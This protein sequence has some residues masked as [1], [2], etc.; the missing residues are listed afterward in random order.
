MSS[1][2]PNTDAVTP[3][4][5]RAKKDFRY[6]FNILMTA[7][8][9]SFVLGALVP[10]FVVIFF[11]LVQGGTNLKPSLFT[12]LPPA[13]M[14][15]DTEVKEI[16][17]GFGNALLGT[18]T[19]VGLGSLISVPIGIFAAIF[20]AEFSSPKI[21]RWL[22]F[23]TNILSGVPSIIIGIFAYA[24]LVSRA[25]GLNPIAIG[26][27]NAI[28]GGFAL[29]LIMLPVIVRTT[30]EALQIV[31]KDVRWASV[32]V[33]A[34]NYQT[35]LRVVLPAALPAVATGIT[36]AVARASG[37]TAPL[38]FTAATQDYWPQ[39]LEELLQSP[40]TFNAKISAIHDLFQSLFQPTHSLAVLVYNFATKGDE[41]QKLIAW[42]ASFLLVIMVLL[43]SIISK[44]ATRRKVY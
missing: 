27:F 23:F 30:D 29:S 14:G 7:T 4:S 19:M 25:G 39:G 40:L 32:G 36:L 6:F 11:V 12:Q 3:L 2:L 26:A 1:D 20:L 31:P 35:V 15:L 17:G 42:A 5:L 33:G 37:E 16:V 21:A 38:V 18:L 13:Q 8:A 41:N 43:T 22:R 28:A 34:S 9:G 24:A 10:L 44:L